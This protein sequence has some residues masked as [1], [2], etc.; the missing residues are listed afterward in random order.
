MRRLLSVLLILLVI[1]GCSSAADEVTIDADEYCAS[2]KDSYYDTY[3]K[4]LSDAEIYSM[5]N[6][7]AEDF[8]D[9]Y[10][11]EAFLDVK[12][13]VLAVIEVSSEETADKVYSQMNTRLDEIKDE[14]AEYIPDEYSKANNA[15]LEK[16][17]SG[18]KN[19]IV[20]IINEK[21]DTIK[22]DIKSKLGIE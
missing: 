21:V 15:Y 17:S 18:S 14:F 7:E 16:I 19:F 20:F 12:S 1:T 10:Y 2:L 11:A 4:E 8:V 13:D 5:F 22:S 9:A 3:M 6:L